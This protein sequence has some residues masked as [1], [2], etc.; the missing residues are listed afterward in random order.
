MSKEI[1]HP[2]GCSEKYAELCALSTSGDLSVEESADLDRHIAVCDA[3]AAL[4]GEYT[5]LTR[6]GMAALASEFAPERESP[7][8]FRERRTEHR[9]K[10]ALQVAGMNEQPESH[11]PRHVPIFGSYKRINRIVS[12]MGAAAV[13][14]LSV[15]GAYELGRKLEARST[16][17][18]Q[19]AIA[20]PLATL[21][22]AD[23]ANRERRDIEAKLATAQKSL[24]EAAAR[25]AAAE[26][27][28]AELTKT[29]TSLLAQVDQVTKTD[30]ATSD[31]LA[32]ITGQRD[33]LQQQL[34]DA[35]ESLELVRQDLN[36]ARQDRQSAVLRATSLEE[37][38]NSLHASMAATDNTRSTDEQF[39]AKDRDIRELMGARQ[40]YIADVVDVRHNGERSKPFGR[41]FYTK[42]KSL[43]F[44]A[45]DLESQP[46]YRETNTF[47]AWGRPDSSSARPI[48]LGIFYMDS[49]K[50]QRW[51]VKS[52]NPDVLAQIN[53]VF[54][55][56][57]PKGGSEKPTSQPFLE[58]YLHTLPVNHP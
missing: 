27:Q 7:S 41:V 50:N 26:K 6:V 37:E 1:L 35:T 5:S 3:C 12:F 47:Q 21:P 18:E 30:R 23:S 25:S 9:L 52:E 22:K 48:S 19:A 58:A 55:T 2:C 29:Q 31:S 42:G 44:Y 32:A 39:L 49:E 34:N 40:L 14:L 28:I 36:Q 17:I 11:A 43:I 45:F 10:E 20:S 53:A 8:P 13:L 51:V 16:R 46:G 4:L 38:V 33:G 54:V 57:E 24:D 15:G 56:V